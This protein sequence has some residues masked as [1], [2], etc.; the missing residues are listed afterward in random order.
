MSGTIKTRLEAVSSSLDTAINK[1]NNL[2]DAGSGGEGNVETCTVTFST[3]FY[4]Q[5]FYSTYINGAFETM[6]TEINSN[7]SAS[8]SNV[9]I[10]TPIVVI[11]GNTNS[12]DKATFSNNV[13]ENLFRKAIYGGAA[14]ANAYQIT[15]GST[16]SIAIALSDF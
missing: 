3:E 9:V 8:L 12:M 14:T 4:A 15:E 6:Y 5:I 10:N 7:S 1:A 11:L 2:P 16:A 13:V